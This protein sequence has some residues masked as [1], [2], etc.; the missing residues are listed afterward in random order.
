MLSSTMFISNS[1]FLSNKI[2]KSKLIHDF[3]SSNPIKTSVLFSRSYH[4]QL[5]QRNFSSISEIR[6]KADNGDSQAMF[7]YGSYLI[8]QNNID[9]GLVYLKKS[10]DLGNFQASTKYV[11]LLY[12]K[13]KETDDIRSKIDF[14]P[15]LQRAA[16]TDDKKFIEKHAFICLQL[17]FYYREGLSSL[18]KLVDKGDKKYCE[19]L[20]T[21]KLLSDNFQISKCIKYLQMSDSPRSKFIIEFFDKASEKAKQSLQKLAD[22]ENDVISSSICI[23]AEL[24]TTGETN[25]I[26][27]VYRRITENSIN[28]PWKTVIL[29]S[30]GTICLG[31]GK[32]DDAFKFYQKA[33]ENGSIEKLYFLSYLRFY[34]F[35][36]D[37]V[38]RKETF[39]M[40]KK[41]Y[42]LQ[43]DTDEYDI[44]QKYAYMLLVGDGCEKNPIEASK[45]L[46][47]KEN[48][49]TT[50]N[51]LLGFALLNSN[52]KSEGLDILHQSADYG[53]TDCQK[54][55][56]FYLLKNDNKIDEA[57]KYLKLASDNNDQEA[58]N[59]LKKIEKGELPD[60][61]DI[62]LPD[63]LNRSENADI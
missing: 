50:D 28:E 42:E 13:I 47:L 61:N 32:F 6:T 18:K 16:S 15:Y 31:I 37:K 49:N 52:K 43:M 27:Q 9:S 53:D 17:P 56:A 62:S 57:K 26:E 4:R 14:I 58:K 41:A 59:I 12:D 8:D 30:V 22:E 40:I 63:L 38:E 34:K 23:F 29:N 35:R 33:Y 46:E 1:S 2:D 55:Y 19:Q 25:R 5:F 10:S 3:S 54:F 39:N 7:D 20:G 36:N 48:K 24:L 45:V 51:L 44:T 60:Q 11:T 21:L